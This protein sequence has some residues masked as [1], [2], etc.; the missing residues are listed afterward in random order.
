MRDS[1]IDSL[2][3]DG[4]QEAHDCCWTWLSKSLA[5]DAKGA[6]AEPDPLPGDETAEDDEPR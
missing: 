1:D 3:A 4:A 5:D 6:A 2:S